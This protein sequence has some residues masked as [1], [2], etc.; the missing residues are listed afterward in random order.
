[1][2]GIP[3]QD[4]LV[5][6]LDVES[7]DAIIIFDMKSSS[8]APHLICQCCRERE[9]KVWTGSRLL[10]ETLAWPQNTDCERLKEIQQYIRNGARM[11]ELGSGVGVVGTYLSAIGSQVLVTDLPTL[12]ENAIDS[13][14]HRNKNIIDSMTTTSTSSSTI[15]N[16]ASCPTWLGA[17]GIRVGNGW[18][19]ATPLDWTQ[20][21]HEQLTHEQTSTIEFIVASDVIFL[22]SM[23]NSLL[24]TVNLLF[25]AS[26]SNNPSFIL[27]FQ[28]RDAN[29]GEESVAFTTVSGFVAEIH[30]RGW[31]LDCLAWR[32]VTVRKETKDGL[33]VNEESEVFVF[34]I[35]P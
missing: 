26:A 19:A 8:Y 17:D 9:C 21:L 28:R 27:S 18:A 1:M 7:S 14:L 10:I 31:S 33:V 29:D 2:K 13:N 5:S 11:I 34:E 30:R 4:P 16:N 24:N 6:R 15:E 22:A 35:T 3:W 25:Q 12:V 32:P 20:P 23:L